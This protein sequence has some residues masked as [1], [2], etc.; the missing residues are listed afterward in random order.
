M[1]PTSIKL[2]DSQLGFD[3]EILSPDLNQVREVPVFS[4]EQVWYFFFLLTVGEFCNCECFK[5]MNK[6]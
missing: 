6:D 2:L 5:R 1:L 4:K 3:D